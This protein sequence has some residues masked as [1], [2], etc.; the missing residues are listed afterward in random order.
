MVNGPWHRLIRFLDQLE[1]AHVTLLGL[2]VP[3]SVSIVSGKSMRL[4]LPLSCVR[5]EVLDDG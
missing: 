5:I 3:L 1:E 4:Y 2:T